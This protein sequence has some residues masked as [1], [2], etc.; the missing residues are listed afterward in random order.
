MGVTGS[1]LNGCRAILDGFNADHRCR[2][3]NTAGDGIPEFASAFGSTADV[4]GF[5]LARLGRE[6]PILGNHPSGTPA[7]RIP[8]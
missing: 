7:M 6:C 1:A 4:I 8:S 5:V 3:A 2:T